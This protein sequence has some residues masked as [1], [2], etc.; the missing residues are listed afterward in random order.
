MARPARSP[1]KPALGEFLRATRESR[2]PEDFG[3]P[4]GLRR[5]TSG[6]RREEVAALAGISTTWYS[7]I[8]QGRTTAVS[9]SAL[10]EIAHALH[11]SDAERAYLFQLADRADPFPADSS[12]QAAA[13]I[14]ALVAAIQSPAYVLDRTWNA[15]A[16][17]PAAGKLFRDWLGSAPRPK[18]GRPA[19]EAPPNL[20][21][22]VFTHPGAPGF[23]V[24][25]EDRAARLVAE[26][27]A[28]S[29]GSR[30]DPA[31]EALVDELRKASAVFDREW[32]SQKVLAREG[33]SRSFTL[34]RKPP[35]HYWQFT[36]RMAQ[37]NDLKLV[38]LHGQ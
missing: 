31:H 5:R 9:V 8:E 15:V 16:W 28:D 1:A 21:R 6:L 12:P 7:W 24:N 14:N 37:Q 26:Y 10:T 11:L 32:R 38:V 22:Y 36:L 13:P 30:N 35:L 20:L 17:N 34:P 18:Q 27:R 23:I 33:G 4:K 29:A 25:W 19:T 2:N 3:L